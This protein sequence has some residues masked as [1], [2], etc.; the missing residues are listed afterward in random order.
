MT[1]KELN[2]RL[3]LGIGLACAVAMGVVANIC[4]YLM[5]TSPNRPNPLMGQTTLWTYKGHGYFIRAWEGALINR[6]LQV[7]LVLWGLGLLCGAVYWLSYSEAPDFSG[8]YFQ[9]LVAL[10]FLAALTSILIP[11]GSIAG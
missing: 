6:S 7:A 1:R 4:S 9:V 8:R 2:N 5:E 10:I 3:F 11:Y